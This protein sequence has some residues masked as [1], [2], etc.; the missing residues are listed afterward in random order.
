MSNVILTGGDG[1]KQDIWLPGMSKGVPLHVRQVSEAI[2]QYDGKLSL[3]RDNKTGDWVV[4][5]E[6]GPIDVPYFP[7]FGLGNDLP[8]VD[9]VNR[10]L[11]ER[12]VAKNGARI[13]QSVVEAQA[14]RKKAVKDRADA[15]TEEAATA[16]EW[17]TRRMGGEGVPSRVFIPRGVA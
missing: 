9:T 7:V 17:A 6:G 2:E 4:L 1:E 16:F 12:D 8:S 10:M 11:F 13:V 14:A 5:R 3:G 15:A